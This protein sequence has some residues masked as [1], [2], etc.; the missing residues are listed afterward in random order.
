VY[1]R[2]ALMRNRSTKPAIFGVPTSTTMAP[3]SPWYER[4]R[5][6]SRLSSS[7]VS[8]PTDTYSPGWLHVRFVIRSMKRR[9]S[10][11]TIGG[12]KHTY[13]QCALT[14]CSPP[15]TDLVVLYMLCICKI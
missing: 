7:M 6:L 14:H 8:Y 1:T 12:S 11:V 9:S 2:A 13:H 4:V 5:Q 10:F 15:S 3:A